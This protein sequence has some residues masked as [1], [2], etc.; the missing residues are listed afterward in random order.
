MVCSTVD[1]VPGV[2]GVF[3]GNVFDDFRDNFT[4]RIGFMYLY[5][6]YNGYRE[7][8]GLPFGVSFIHRM[9]GKFL[10]F[11]LS[12][13]AIYD[14]MDLNGWNNISTTFL[15]FSESIH[16]RSNLIEE[17]VFLAFALGN[18]LVHPQDSV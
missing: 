11:G 16:P 14:N 12:G 18:H 13:S 17:G 6:P 9:G 15:Y 2:Q 3:I 10:E 7:M 4:T 8:I 1:D 5:I